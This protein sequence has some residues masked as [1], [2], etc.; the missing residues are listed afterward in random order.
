[1]SIFTNILDRLGIARKAEIKNLERWQ[2]ETA[3]AQQWTL[4][5]PYIFAN[6]AD[7]YRLDPN[8]GTVL[9]KFA[10]SVGLLTFNVRRRKEE[11]LVDIPNHEFEVLIDSPN[12]LMTGMELLMSTIMDYKLNGNATWWLNRQ[13]YYQKPVEI[14]YIPFNQMKP[15]PDGRLYLA[16]Y[17]YSPGNGKEPVML[18]PWQVVHFKTYNPFNNFIGLSPIES[19]VDTIA[20]DIGMR[21]TQRQYYVGNRG[22]PPSVLA[23]K[24]FIQDDA[25]TDIKNKVRKSAEE[26]NMLLLRGV[27]EAVT[28]MSRAMSNKDMDVVSLFEQNR[29]AIWDRMVPGAMAMM[30][31]GANRSTADAARAT[32]TE[33][34]WEV[35]QILA[36]KI[37]KEILYT[38]T[39]GDKLVGEFEDPRIVD[40]QLELAEIQEY[41]KYHSLEEVR[42]EK[43]QHDP[44]GDDRDKLLVAQ[45][46]AQTGDGTEKPTPPQLQP[47]TG[48]DMT[49]Q[50]QGQT[51]DNPEDEQSTDTPMPD[52]NKAT[53]TALF[54]LRKIIAG[55]RT[56][57]AREFS[58]ADIPPLMLQAVKAHIDT[59]DAVAFI[60][61][62]IERLQPKAQPTGSEILRGLEATV[63]AMELSRK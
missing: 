16:G 23:F 18:P 9:E 53:R 4:P 61:K 12:P 55:G 36:K 39:W 13:G 60:N 25:W 21:K 50:P 24:D 6:Q 31:V 56:D 10:Q 19:L 32:Y 45:I 62:Q 15:V 57:K 38:Y 41:S 7:L 34:M 43:Y 14:W 26:N 37:T 49:E 11:E 30:D 44:L 51:L 42:K 46:N 22:E 1:M 52:A 40:R 28:W 63:K 58:N 3:D 35:A 27:G 8:L 33:S 48:Q 20:G 5:D 17:E 54:R 59:G 2:R 29:K 47:F